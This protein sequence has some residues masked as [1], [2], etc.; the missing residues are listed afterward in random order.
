M[1][2]QL[3]REILKRFAWAWAD[4]RDAE[5]NDLS[6]ALEQRQRSGHRKQ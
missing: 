1:R 3:N 2:P 5:P 6:S 4:F